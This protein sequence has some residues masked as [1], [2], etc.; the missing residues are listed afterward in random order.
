M[1]AIWTIFN[2]EAWCVCVYDD[3]VSTSIIIII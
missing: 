2:R 3:D 1:Y